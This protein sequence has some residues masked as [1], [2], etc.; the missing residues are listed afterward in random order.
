[1]KFEWDGDKKKSNERKHGVSFEEAATL[2][3]DPLALIFDD[4]WH[5]SIE[6]REIIIGH[7]ANQRLLIV[8]FTERNGVVRLISAREATKKER[9]DY[10]ENA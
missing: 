3:A 4:E 6:V 8:S 5:S 1:M 9:K 10:E 7:S 2:F